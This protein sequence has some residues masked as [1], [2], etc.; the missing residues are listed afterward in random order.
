MSFN[1]KVLI[2]SQTEEGFNLPQKRI[3][4]IVRLENESGVTT[5]FLSTV[6]FKLNEFGEFYLFLIGGDVLK[7]FSLGKKLGSKTFTID[8]PF[9]I[10]QSLSVGVIFIKDGFPVTVAYA[11]EKKEGG[12]QNF[13]KRVYDKLLTDLK[14]RKEQEKEDDVPNFPMIPGVPLPRQFPDKANPQFPNVDPLGPNLSAPYDDEVVATENYFGEDQDFNE[15][16]K[17]IEELA[18]K[19]VRIENGL[20][21]FFDKE[22]TQ[23]NEGDSCLNQDEIS[24][25]NG[26]KPKEFGEQNPYYLTKKKELDL[27]FEKFPKEEILSKN[28]SGDKWVKITYALDKYYVVG[29][30]YQDGK[31]KYICYGVPSNY[32]ETPP[33]ELK[34]LC[35]FVPLSVFDLKGKG[36]WIMFQDA[37]TGKHVDKN[38]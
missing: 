28:F 2:L 21:N 1:K 20:F 10:N 36:Y 11:D 27:I 24:Y 4:G 7:Q 37:I 30:I 14:K 17:I 13:K 18:G 15:K 19:D 25:E 22:K 9:D 29:L 32:S 5:L 34:G 12:L 38:V 31:E 6:N 33:K 23:K 3:S 26:G 8:C 16:L 35:S